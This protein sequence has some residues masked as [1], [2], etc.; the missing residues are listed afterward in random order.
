MAIV[1]RRRRPAKERFWAKVQLASLRECWN[2]MG[3]KNERGA[4]LFSVM[5]KGQKMMQAHRYSWEI[6][7]GRIPAGKQVLHCCD[8]PSRVNPGHLWLG[9]HHDNM[10]DMKAK[11]RA[12]NNRGIGYREKLT[13]AMVR[14]I[15]ARAEADAETWAALGRAYGVH[16]ETIR[17]LVLRRSWRKRRMT[18]V[19][20]YPRRG[21]CPN[22][23]FRVRLW[24]N[25]W[26]A[27]HRL[28]PGDHGQ[29]WR[30]CHGRGRVPVEGLP[31]HNEV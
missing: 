29:P 26:V 3:G 1:D 22:C 10:L 31:A 24:K 20:A 28:Y 7:F 13:V 21:T 15:R 17:R 25:G 4:G 27:A 23:G 19:N 11:G 6:A 12:R 18:D 30:H 8:N 2:W 9:T 14:E 16:E 5:R